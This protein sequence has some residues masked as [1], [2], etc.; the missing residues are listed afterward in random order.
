MLRVDGSTVI[1]STAAVVQQQ[2]VYGRCGL[3]V[4]TLVIYVEDHSAHRRIANAIP[5]TYVLV[6]LPGIFYLTGGERATSP[7]SPQLL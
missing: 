1:L 2:Y 4:E 5:G 7:S 3:A 6:I